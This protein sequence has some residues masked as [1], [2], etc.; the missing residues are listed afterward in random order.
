M[1]GRVDPGGE[2]YSYRCLASEGGCGSMRRNG[3]PVEKYV[4]DLF[5]EAT[6]RSLGVVEHDEIDDA[7]YDERIKQLREEIK[8]VMARRKPDHPKRITTA[9]AMDLVSELETEIA[10]LTYKARTLTAAKVRRQ[11]DAPSL[12]KEWGSYT[13][14]MKRDRLRRDITAVV[15]NRSGKGFRFN[16][17]LIEVA[18]VS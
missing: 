12:L 16:P 11:Q 18:W 10:D 6:R 1:Y 3:P 8:E 7:I 9:V 14:D 4:E 2:R 17:A 15:I 13:I 5:L